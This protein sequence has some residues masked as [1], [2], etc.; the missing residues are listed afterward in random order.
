MVSE[1]YI[2]LK[3]HFQTGPKC[4]YRV[5]TVHTSIQLYITHQMHQMRLS[6]LAHWTRRADAR[7]LE[8]LRGVRRDSEMFLHIA[9][10]CMRYESMPY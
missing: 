5:G 2:I 6:E 1:N 3:L 9:G 7:R 4:V 10:K 8:E